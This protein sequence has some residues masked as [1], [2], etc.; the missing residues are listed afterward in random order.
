MVFVCAICFICVNWFY[1]GWIIYL[2]VWVWLVL[3]SVACDL[4][5]WIRV[6]IYLCL[7]YLVDFRSNCCVCG[8]YLRCTLLALWFDDIVL[9]LALC[10]FKCWE[11][12]FYDLIYLCGVLDNSVA[13]FY[14]VYVCVLC[15]IVLFDWINLV[16][17]YILWLTGWV[18]FEMLFGLLVWVWVVEWIVLFW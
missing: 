13:W 17:F 18:R 6:I 3:N 8:L 11:F 5:I 1:F 9:L 14:M 4:L 16:I 12:A 10:C 7:F 15:Y 2:I